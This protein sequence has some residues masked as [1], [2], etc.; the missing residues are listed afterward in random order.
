[1]THSIVSDSTRVLAFLLRVASDQLF[2]IASEAKQSRIFRGEILDCFV[3]V[4]PRKDGVDG[5]RRHQCAR[6]VV[7]IRPDKGAVHDED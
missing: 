3:A 5:P 7:V 4:A 2:V 1:M 6:L